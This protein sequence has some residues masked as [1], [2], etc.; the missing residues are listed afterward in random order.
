MVAESDTAGLVGKRVVGEIN[1]P[2]GKCPLCAKGL[3]KHC[4]RRSVLGIQGRDG[5]FAEYLVL[6][7]TNL[8]LV[9]DG[10]DD[11][12]AVFVEPLAAACQAVNQAAVQEGETA[13]VLGDGKLGQLVARVF[14]AYEIPV[15]LI[16]K[17]PE[18]LR[19]AEEAGFAAEYSDRISQKRDVDVIVDATG[20][21]SALAY[22][23][24]TVRP[25]GRIIL[26]T[27]IA[28]SYTI[29]LAPLVVDEITLIGS[30]CGPFTDALELL[31]THKV[32]VHNLISDKCL[33]ERGVLALE[34][35]IS[36]SALKVILKIQEP[37]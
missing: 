8:H 15:T 10:I 19:L 4:A 29:D 31:A 6:P 11:D 7:E 16:G 36:S 2:C 28:Q 27:T 26:K 32:N 18:K 24:A 9:P 22:S 1:C 37:V 13:L 21:P 35:A 25:A 23:L 33:L 5:A 30:R 17:H 20:S 3:G 12:T 14:H 34:K